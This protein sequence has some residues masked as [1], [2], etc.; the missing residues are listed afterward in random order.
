MKS[1]LE[2]SSSLEAI[3]IW[4]S[5]IEDEGEDPRGKRSPGAREESED[6]FFKYQARKQRKEKGA[7][8]FVAVRRKVLTECLIRSINELNIKEKS[9]LNS[10]LELI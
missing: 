3:R 5:E 10:E 1:S 2:K 8:V 9:I 6:E 4:V 7:R